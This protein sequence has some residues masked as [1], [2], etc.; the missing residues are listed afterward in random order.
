MEPS[1]SRR[2]SLAN[3]ELELTVFDRSA[4]RTWSA[5]APAGPAFQPV[6]DV[7]AFPC[8]GES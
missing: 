8:Q 7:A 5:M 3:V 2:T 4:H 1:P 6:Q